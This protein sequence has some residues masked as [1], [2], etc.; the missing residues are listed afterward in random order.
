METINL[1]HITEQMLSSGG[2]PFTDVRENLDT[3]TGFTLYEIV[4]TSPTLYIANFQEN[5]SAINFIVQRIAEEK[6]PGVKSYFFVDVGGHYKRIIDELKVK[7]KIMAERARSY[8]RD[9]ECEPMPAY[10]RLI[11][12]SFLSNYPEVVTESKG[13]GAERKL[14]IKY[15]ADKGK[16]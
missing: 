14:I 1:K 7:A 9:I 2:F 8:K 12:H 11:I 4:T 10:E 16:I 15:N 3:E 6:M 5:L 13:M